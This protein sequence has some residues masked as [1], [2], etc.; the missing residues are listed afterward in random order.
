VG[1]PERV[2]PRDKPFRAAPV[3]ATFL[4]MNERQRDLF[5]WQWSRRRA[6]GK[7]AIALRGAGVGALGG[8]LFGVMLS[9]GPGPD[10]HAYDTL[11][12]L[13]AGVG[14]YLLSIPVFCLLGW[15]GAR[16]VFSQQEAMYQALLAAGARVPA[17]KPVLRAGDRGPLIAVVATVVLILGFILCVARLY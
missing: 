5:L 1:F 16:R 2:F 8:I 17:Q 11:G 13:G 9:P 3:R 10:V 4:V 6:P 14:V 12:Q 7:A 15:H